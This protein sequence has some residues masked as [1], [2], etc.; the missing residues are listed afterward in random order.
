MRYFIGSSVDRWPKNKD[1]E[2][3]WLATMDPQA[4]L[5][6][7]SH[8]RAIPHAFVS[9]ATIAEGFR[10]ARRILGCPPARMVYMSTQI[11]EPEQQ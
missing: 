2:I 7:D 3:S 9:G 1:R 8:W 6:P 10:E 5:K 4:K 11:P